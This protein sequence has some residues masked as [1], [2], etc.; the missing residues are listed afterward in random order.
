MIELYN[1]DCQETIKKLKDQNRKVDCI[2]TS[3]PYNIEIDYNSY[4]DNKNHLEYIKWLSDIF[5]DCYDILETGGRLC[6]NIA[7]QKN[8][9]VPT[10]SDIIQS[11]V[12][13]GPYIMNTII[14]WNRNYV[15]SRTSWGSWLSP[16][17]PSYPTPFEYILIFSKETKKL[18]KEGIT[19]LTR[20]EF[21]E[22]TWGIWN[23]TPETK[24]KSMNHPAPFPAE[25]PKRLIKM[26]TYKGMTV[27]DPFMGTGTT[28]YV[29][30]KY[31]RNF[32]GS[33]IDEKYF[34]FA[35]KRIDGVLDEWN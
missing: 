24:A 12:R 2:I 18:Q 16:S 20:D 6:I 35:Q 33:E 3:P 29:C 31:D 26:N 28:G 22:N 30:K 27:Y 34:K 14:I 25:L 7:D 5:I 32:I 13:N 23:F 9:R 15:A 1:E 21:I 8:G 4:D 19:D 10:H 17:C 11:L